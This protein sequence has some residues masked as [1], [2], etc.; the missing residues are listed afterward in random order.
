MKP[1]THHL[2]VSTAPKPSALINMFMSLVAGYPMLQTH[3]ALAE[4]DTHRKQYQQVLSIFTT[5][6]DT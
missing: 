5:S 3:L 1:Y 6:E 2:K 4:I